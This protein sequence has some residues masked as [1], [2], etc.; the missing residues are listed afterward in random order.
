MKIVKF[1]M[2]LSNQKTIDLMGNFLLEFLLPNLLPPNLPRKACQ[3]AKLHIFQNSVFGT[4]DGIALVCTFK[5]RWDD[6][7]KFKV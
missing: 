6:I 1:Y 7:D 4:K 5:T 3:K 2:K